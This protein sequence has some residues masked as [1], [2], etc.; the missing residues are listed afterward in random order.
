MATNA[1]MHLVRGSF[2]LLLMIWVVAKLFLFA[3]G[4]RVPRAVNSTPVLKHIAQEIY[5]VL[6]LQASSLE[7]IERGQLEVALAWLRKSL[8]RLQGGLSGSGM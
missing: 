2:A 3:G 8:L 4:R 1:P 6:L 7:L 5:P